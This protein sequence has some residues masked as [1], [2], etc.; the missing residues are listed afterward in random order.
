[1]P[2]SLG[3]HSLQRKE[4]GKSVC[5]VLGQWHPGQTEEA[6]W[7]HLWVISHGKLDKIVVTI[8]CHSVFHLTAP[9]HFA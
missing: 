7:S 5:R 3:A 2:G 9:I 8:I 6:H 4:K 1:M